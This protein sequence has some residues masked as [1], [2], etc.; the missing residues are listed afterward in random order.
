MKK[1]AL[2]LAVLVML[3]S[4]TSSVF[5]AVNPVTPST[6]EIN[7]TNGWAHVDLVSHGFRQC[8]T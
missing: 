1:F 3:M 6:N 7:K 5:A 4:A 8:D 2:A